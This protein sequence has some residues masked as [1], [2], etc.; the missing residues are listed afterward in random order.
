MSVEAPAQ[1]ENNMFCCGATLMVHE[2]KLKYACFVSAV[3]GSGVPSDLLWFSGVSSGL[4]GVSRR[5]G[6]CEGRPQPDGPPAAD[7]AFHIQNVTANVATA[8]AFRKWAQAAGREGGAQ[9]AEQGETGG[10]REKGTER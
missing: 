5:P 8:E 1:R 6:R 10:R 7:T 4:P 2:Q 9:G 3:G